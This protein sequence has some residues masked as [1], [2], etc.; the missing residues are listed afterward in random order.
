MGDLPHCQGYACV[1]RWGGW[2]RHAAA[3]TNPIM[4][5]TTQPIQSKLASISSQLNDIAARVGAALQSIGSGA[6][7]QPQGTR[8]TSGPGSRLTEAERQEA[9]SMLRQPDRYT[10]QQIADHLRI[11]RAAVYL[12]AR[13]A[14]LDEH[15][16]GPWASQISHPLDHLMT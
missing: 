6:R 15:K 9:I 4:S 3:P 8:P 5:S 1:I 10:V 7:I 16:R 12:I 13:A 14:N 11:T 2:A